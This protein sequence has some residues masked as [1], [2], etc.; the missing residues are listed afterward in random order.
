MMIQQTVCFLKV[1]GLFSCVGHDTHLTGESPVTGVT[2]KCSEPQAE[3]R[4]AQ[5]KE[6]V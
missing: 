6:A 5:V 1:D 4:E 2:A 3:S